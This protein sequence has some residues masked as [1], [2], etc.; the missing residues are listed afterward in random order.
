M[1]AGRLPAERDHFFRCNPLFA[2]FI[3]LICAAVLH[4]AFSKIRSVV[5]VAFAKIFSV[6]FTW[7]CHPLPRRAAL[8]ASSALTRAGFD[9][10]LDQRRRIGRKV[11]ARIG[12]SCDRPD[13]APV[14]AYFKS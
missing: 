5:M 14:A 7:F 12:R 8:R 9:A 13:R 11:R 2:I 3:L 10:R 6:S 1:L 4:I